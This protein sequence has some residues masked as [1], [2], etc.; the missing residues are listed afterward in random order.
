MPCK[1]KGCWRVRECGKGDD[2]FA[3]VYEGVYKEEWEDVLGGYAR[4]RERCASRCTR[5]EYTRYMYER[6]YECMKI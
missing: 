3:R 4:R 5:E 6:M 1:R 2:K